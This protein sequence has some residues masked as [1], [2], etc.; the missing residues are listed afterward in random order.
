MSKRH[1]SRNTVGS[2]GK[3]RIAKLTDLSVESVKNG[4]Y[5]RA[6]RY[7]TLARRIGMKTRVKMPEGFRYCKEC[8]TPM[9]PGVNCRV[10]L[11]NHK[12][13]SGCEICG[14]FRRM[15]YN[16]ERAK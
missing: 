9:I 8:N 7:V 3:E 13:T 4:N 10:R 6:Q 2:I 15:P 16:R 14:S 5:V 12:I 1:L 11:T